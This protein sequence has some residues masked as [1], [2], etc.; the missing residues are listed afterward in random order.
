MGEGD[1][2]EIHAGS[3]VLCLNFAPIPPTLVA[4]WNYSWTPAL[5][6]AGRELA[7]EFH[8]T[9]G[10][11]KSNLIRIKDQTSSVHLYLAPIDI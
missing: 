7:V 2:R 1:R 4:Q 10:L 3:H 9:C 11:V 6:Q 5:L 8:F